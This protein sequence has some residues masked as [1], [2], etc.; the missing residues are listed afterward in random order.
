MAL[1]VLKDPTQRS[2]QLWV[3]AFYILSNL[4]LAVSILCDIWYAEY[5]YYYIIVL[6]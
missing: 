3:R 6:L 2:V 1:S 4:I 5:K